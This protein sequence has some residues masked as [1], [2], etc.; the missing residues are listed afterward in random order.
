MSEALL[1]LAIISWWQCTLD[2][3]GAQRNLE[4]PKVVIAMPDQ[5]RARQGG[6]VR[7]YYD[8]V[9]NTVTA[10]DRKAVIHEFFHAALYQ[11]EGLAAMR[12]ELRVR[13]AAGRAMKA[14]EEG[15]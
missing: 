8:Y 11:T 4:M 15:P 10:V 12:D 14:I 9:T 7:G 3:L 2:T 13:E 6:E 5:S 1:Y